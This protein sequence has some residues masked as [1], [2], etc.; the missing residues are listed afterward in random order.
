MRNIKMYV[1][2]AFLLFFSGCES[3]RQYYS[4]G[5]SAPRFD[6][7]SS[8]YILL[9]QD[10]MYYSRVCIGS[11]R[12]I[13]QIISDS[14]SRHLTRIETSGEVEELADGLK[15]AKE[16]GYAYLVSSKI[17]RWEDANT[18]WSGKVDKIQMQMSI[19]DVQTNNLLHSVDF[20][21]NSS[22]FLAGIFGCRP[23]YI[24]SKSIDDYVANLFRS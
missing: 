19:Y 14:F 16:K 10:A 6:S 5:S 22:W 1:F 21:G 24:V 13:A 18:G 4:G 8:V 12:S 15:K 17:I 7:N 20:E 2:L 9:P 11:G 3:A 23:Y